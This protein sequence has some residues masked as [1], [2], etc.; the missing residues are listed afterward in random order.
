MR[1]A[2]DDPVKPVG[3][4]ALSVQSPQYFN[5]LRICNCVEMCGQISHSQMLSLINVGWKEYLTV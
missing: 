2:I 4:H 3:S 5:G 1:K